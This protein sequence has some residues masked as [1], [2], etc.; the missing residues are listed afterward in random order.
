MVLGVRAGEVTL[1]GYTVMHP[2]GH[3]GFWVTL[4]NAR[5]PPGSVSTLIIAP[6]QVGTWRERLAFP[7]SCQAGALSLTPTSLSFL[8]FFLG[9]LTAARV[10]EVCH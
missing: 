2:L 6:G 10:L 1:T 5:L 9:P 4:Q 8:I 7:H 3:S